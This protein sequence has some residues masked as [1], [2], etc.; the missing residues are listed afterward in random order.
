MQEH[1]FV[2]RRVKMVEIE[3]KKQVKGD[4]KGEMQSAML[5]PMTQPRV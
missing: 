1:A 5:R 4:W 2:I 3:V